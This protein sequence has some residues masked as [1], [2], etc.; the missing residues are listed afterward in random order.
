MTTK[1][2]DLIGVIATRAKAIDFWSFMHYLPNPD[3]VLK[4]MGRDISV[5]RE[6]LSDSHV[7]GCVRRRKAAIKGLEWRITPTGNEKQMKS[8]PRFLTVYR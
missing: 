7:G 3:P 4:K 6:I 5:Y 8:W 2:Q 1:K